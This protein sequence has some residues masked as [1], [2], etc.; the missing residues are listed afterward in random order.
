MENQI[1][2]GPDMQQALDRTA[3]RQLAGRTYN[4]LGWSFVVFLAAMLVLPSIVV[5]A[6]SIADPNALSHPF[7]GMPLNYL[8]MYLIGF[9]LMLLV[10]RGLPPAPAMP[11]VAPEKKLKP[12]T[13]LALYPVTYAITSLVSILTAVVE[14]LLGTAA[15][16][17]TQDII[18]MGAPQW[19]TFVLGVVVAPV[20]EELVF[21]RL[22]YRRA[23][24]YGKGA[25]MLWS[26]VVFGL[27]HLNLGQS[28]YAAVLGGLF[29]YV[30]LR[31]GSVLYPMILHVALN[32]TGGIGIGSI[33]L[34]SGSETAITVYT[35]YSYALILLGT[36]I[37]IV[38]LVRVLRAR[39]NAPPDTGALPKRAAFLNAG[40]LV[41]CGICAAIILGLMVMSAMM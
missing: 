36:V 10:L 6:V 34:S 5:V 7:F 18:D 14:A 27:F 23:A 29:A 41:Y 22:V 31:N 28:A 16:T 25:F 12:L 26:A 8:C 20:M 30:M 2:N 37:G 35:G 39:R 15:T 24:G 40:S 11:P 17:T 32:F 38:M 19:I 13:L 3:Q 33:I 4:R 21:R 1:N 9:P